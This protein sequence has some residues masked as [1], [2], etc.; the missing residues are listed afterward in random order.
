[1]TEEIII[2]GV[3]VV[4]CIHYSGHLQEY[5]G[6]NKCEVEGRC[7]REKN[8]YYKQLQ[9]LKQENEKLNEDLKQYSEWLDEERKD[10]DKLQQVYQDEHCD[11][12]ELRKALEEIKNDCVEILATIA[13]EGKPAGSIIDTIWCK[14]IPCCTLW[15]LVECMQNKINEVLE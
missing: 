8:C 11:L 14:N 13:E 10:N 12:L 2:D 5:L 15:E 1:M 9:R 7:E 6:T 3:N 4:D